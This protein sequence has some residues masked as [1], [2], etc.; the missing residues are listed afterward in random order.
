M[1]DTRH[2]H[3]GEKREAEHEGGGDRETDEQR[4]PRAEGREHHDQS[5]VRS[6]SGPSFSSWLTIEIH[7]ARLVVRGADIYHR[8]QPF[9]PGFGRRGDLVLYEACGVDE[10]EA[11]PLDDLKRDRG[12]RR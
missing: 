1:F 8:A 4:R 7:L 10:V 11:L 9:G 6:R 2:A 3:D 5:R 12:S